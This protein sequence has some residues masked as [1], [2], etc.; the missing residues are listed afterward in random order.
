M[1]VKSVYIVEGVRTPLGSFG[2]SLS[3]LSAPRLASVAIRALLERTGV[4][5]DWIGEVLIGHVLSAGVG[6][7]PARQAALYAGLPK[8]IPCTTVNKVCSSGMKAIILGARTL[9]SGDYDLVL[10]G[11]M[12]SMSNVPFY[13]F[14][15]RRGHKL[16]DTK[17]VDGLI[18][19]GLW[20]PHYQ[21]HMGNC[22]EVCAV[23]YKIPREEQ[24]AY[25]AASYRRSA[26][27][28]SKGYFRQEVVPV[29]VSTK[30]GTQVVDEDEEY[31][32]VDFE[33]MRRLPP[34]F[35]KEGTV[36]AA[37]ASTIN[38]GAAM[39]LLATEEAVRRYGLKP[40]ARIVGWAEAATDPM[41]FTIAPALAVRR[42]LDRVGW[43]VEDVDY[44]EIN[45]AFSVVV[46]ANM[47]ELG[48]SHDRVNVFGGAV[49][50]GHP[51]GCSG[52]RIVVTLL[53]VLRVHG[54]KRGV[55]AIC[56]GGGGASALA[57]EMV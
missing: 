13:V 41:W 37:N 31:K 8:E 53:S 45:E 20:D 16:G 28:W 1:A 44:W 12:E 38:D 17:L 23:E 6:Q 19:D 43:K 36:T 3:S 7:A 10:A 2:G 51:I 14:E 56:N 11:G 18:Y 57:V 34:V 50:L 9:L 15:M 27:A 24:D 33:K 21:K 55:A 30:K 47:K 40:V 4:S 54:G 46:L 35:D 26:E 49:S 48:L 29:E 22:A 52:A 32:R 25:A 42:L 5:G 39:V